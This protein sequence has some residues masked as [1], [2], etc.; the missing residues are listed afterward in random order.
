MK[1]TKKRRSLVYCLHTVDVRIRYIEYLFCWRLTIWFRLNASWYLLNIYIHG[2]P[3]WLETRRD[4]YRTWNP[5]WTFD[6]DTSILFSVSKDTP[7]LEDSIPPRILRTVERR[8]GNE[9]SSVSSIE[10]L[11]MP[12]T[13]FL[14]WSFFVDY[15]QT[16]IR[17]Q[18]QDI[19][20]LICSQVTPDTIRMFRLINQLR[21]FWETTHNVD[22]IEI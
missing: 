3:L 11:S 2:I 13:I 8:L 22:R 10:G 1:K 7:Y 15:D 18:G 19:V 4:T 21:F 12:L 20:R 6:T 5:L 16:T 9:T 17:H 14:R